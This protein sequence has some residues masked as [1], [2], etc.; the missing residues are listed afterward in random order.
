MSYS[1]RLTG[2]STSVDLKVKPWATTPIRR[3]VAWEQDSSGRFLP[4]DRGS[5][6]DWYDAQVTVFGQKAEMETFGSWLDTEAGETFTIAVT[7]GVLFAPNVDQTTANTATILDM[8]RLKRLFWASPTNGVDE[9]TFTLR[10]VSPT[11]YETAGS[12]AGLR[13]QPEYE[14]DSSWSRT[15]TFTQSGDVVHHDRRDRAGRFPGRFKQTTAEM[16]PILNFLMGG[17]R[18]EAFTFPTLPGVTYPFGIARGGLPL[19]CR[20]PEF[21]VSREGLNFW[22]L[23][24]DFVEDFS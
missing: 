16:I 5:Q 19:S 15:P 4:S 1:I 21:S 8:D 11:L 6:A 7:N 24:I 23:S 14:Q 2:E 10:L 22:N 9:V 13:L 17:G 12:L 18:A 3:N 20:A